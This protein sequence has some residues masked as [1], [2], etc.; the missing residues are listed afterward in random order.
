MT[1]PLSLSRLTR[2]LSTAFRAWLLQDISVRLDTI[3]KITIH[4]KEIAMASQADID[5]LTANVAS[6]KDQ[7]STDN[8]ELALA[9]GRISDKLAE[10]AG[11][12]VDVSALQAEVGNL[13]NVI[14]D[15]SSTVDQ[16]E[17]LVPPA[18]E[19]T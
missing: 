11:Q 12:G 1:S 5:A 2:D 4:T 17:G 16:T 13:Q 15:I 18:V 14:T 9:V 6:L 8:S 7:V 19:P 3:K 10:L